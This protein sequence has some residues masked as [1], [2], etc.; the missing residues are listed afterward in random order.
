MIKSYTTMFA[1]PCTQDTGKR[2]DRP[3]QPTWKLQGPK[4]KTQQ[5]GHGYCQTLPCVVSSTGHYK[6]CPDGKSLENANRHVRATSHFLTRHGIWW[7]YCLHQTLYSDEDRF[8][9]YVSDMTLKPK[10]PSLL[11]FKNA[12]LQRF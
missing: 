6:N 12:R 1:I 4:P 5:R 7:V 9:R 11:W 2:M 10:A 8:N 3:L